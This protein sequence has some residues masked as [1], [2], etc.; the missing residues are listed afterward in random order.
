MILFSGKTCKLA[1]TL[2]FAASF[3]AVYAGKRNEFTAE[4]KAWWAVQPLQE[5]KVTEGAHPVDFFLERKLKEAG[6]EMAEGA[7]AEEFVRRVYFDLH[8]LPPSVD[9]RDGLSRCVGGRQRLSG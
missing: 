1:L 8:G 2:F 4:E 7:T 3:H 6:L 5:T 9:D